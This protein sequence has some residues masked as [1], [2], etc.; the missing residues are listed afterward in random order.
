MCFLDVQDLC[1]LQKCRDVSFLASEEMR[2]RA[3]Q[4]VRVMLRKRPGS[5][6][7]EW[8][9]E[10]PQKVEGSARPGGRVSGCACVVACRRHVLLP[11]LRR[12]RKRRGNRSLVVVLVVVVHGVVTAPKQRWCHGVVVLRCRREGGRGRNERV[13]LSIRRALRPWRVLAATAGGCVL[14]AERGQ[15]SGATQLGPGWRW[16]VSQGAGRRGAVSV[17]ASPPVLDVGVGDR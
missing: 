14:G 3:F 8:T 11:A 2:E 17:G 12:W 15:R 13:R 10:G 16:A 7:V 5:V 1:L 6:G 9:C 4:V